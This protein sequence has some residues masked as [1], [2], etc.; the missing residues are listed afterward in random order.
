MSDSRNLVQ[1]PCRPSALSPRRPLAR[2]PF[3]VRL[4]LLPL[5]IFHSL[6]SILYFPFSFLFVPSLQECSDQE[7]DRDHGL[8]HRAQAHGKD[9]GACPG[10]SGQDRHGH[11]HAGGRTADKEGSP[12]PVVITETNTSTPIKH[13]VIPSAIHSMVMMRRLSSE[14]GPNPLTIPGVGRRCPTPQRKITAEPV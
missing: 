11:E 1:S 3:R 6:F 2:S 14:R 5:S 7:G 10:E 13:R 9:G 8:D 12:G 4:S